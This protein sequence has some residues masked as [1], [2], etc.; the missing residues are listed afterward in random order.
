MSHHGIANKITACT[1]IVFF[2]RSVT[3]GLCSEECASFTVQSVGKAYEQHSFSLQNRSIFK[4]SFT[5][6]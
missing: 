2:G 3:A 4:N 1:V 5:I 6:I